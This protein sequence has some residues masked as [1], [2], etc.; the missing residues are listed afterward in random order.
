MLLPYR[1]QIVVSE[2]KRTI[3]DYPSVIRELNARFSLGLEE[4]ET[5]GELE[6][7]V[8]PV[9]KEHLG[10]SIDRDLV[11]KETR[12]NFDSSADPQLLQRATEAYHKFIA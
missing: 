10:P 1:E 6:E 4:V 9:S 7:L 5:Q 8:I 3:T 12:A 2:F 11:K